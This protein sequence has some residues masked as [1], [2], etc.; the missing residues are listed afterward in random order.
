MSHL[1]IKISGKKSRQVALRKG[2]NSGVY[3]LT[4]YKCHPPQCQN[5][6]VARQFDELRKMN[7]W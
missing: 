4:E 7:G 5:N 3:G 1:K 6:R 2:F